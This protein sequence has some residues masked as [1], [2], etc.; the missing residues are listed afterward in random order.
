MVTVGQ[1]FIVI[2]RLKQ[3]IQHVSLVNGIVILMMLRYI[4]LMV[5]ATWGAQRG[6]IVLCEVSLFG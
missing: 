5:E 2:A 1:L 6:H 3:W 4:V